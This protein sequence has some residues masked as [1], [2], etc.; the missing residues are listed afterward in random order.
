MPIRFG[1][2]DVQHTTERQSI[3]CAGRIEN[4]GRSVFGHAHDPLRQI[5][6][7]DH[8]RVILAGVSGTSAC[9]ENV[10]ERY[11]SLDAGRDGAGFAERS[12]NAAS[13][14]AVLMY[15]S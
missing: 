8:P 15:S 5:A 1:A 14:L 4:A 11:S 9:Q 7:V 13:A 2:A 6:G 12:A 10:A 3:L